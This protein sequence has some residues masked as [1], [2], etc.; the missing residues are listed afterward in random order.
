MDAR[1][2]HAA[3]LVARTPSGLSPGTSP[4]D[5]ALSQLG[6]EVAQAAHAIRDPGDPSV[7]CSR[8]R[9]HHAPYFRWANR[10]IQRMVEMRFAPPENLKRVPGP[11]ALLYSPPRDPELQG[12]QVPLPR[13]SRTIW[14][15]L[16]TTG[17]LLARSKE[18][19]H[20]NDPREA[21]EEMQMDAE[22][23]GLCLA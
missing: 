23:C 13:S 14:K 6:E 15:I 8:S 20:P 7:L 12:A 16:H 11:R 18:P 19:P 22:R 5:R 3:R 4:R 17:C 9:A 2:C 1:S 10:V 21:L